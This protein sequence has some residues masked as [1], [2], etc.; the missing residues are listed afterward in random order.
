MV[1]EFELL[2]SSG[3]K[4]TDEDI[5]KQCIKIFDEPQITKEKADHIPDT[6]IFYQGEEKP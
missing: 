6:S 2:K 1:N 3:K 5:A 4:H